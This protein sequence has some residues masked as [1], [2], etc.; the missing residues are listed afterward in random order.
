[1]TGP[2]LFYLSSSVLATAAFFMLN[3]LAHRMRT[4]QTRE[5]ADLAPLPDVTY[6][7]FG[8]EETPDPP[9][10]PAAEAG[11]AIPVAMAFLGLTFICCALLI[12]GLPPLSGFVAKFALLHATVAES[13]ENGA[14]WYGGAFCAAVLISGIAAVIALSRIGLRLFWSVGDRRTPRLR[15]IEA[16]PPGFLILLCLGLSAGAEPVMTYLNSAA[17]SLHSPEIYIEVVLS[18]RGSQQ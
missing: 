14:S 15:V 16:A 11:V 6:A 10:Q 1:L 8:A 4:F 9:P 2:V 7:G 12:A 3:G 18:T 5:A 17:Q 13:A